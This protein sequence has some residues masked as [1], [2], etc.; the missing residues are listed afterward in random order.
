MLRHLQQPNQTSAMSW[1]L[2]FAR[3]PA[4][5]AA[6]RRLSVVCLAG[7]VVG[8]AQPLLSGPAAAQSTR[9]AKHAEI[10]GTPQLKWQPAN[11]TVAPGGTVTFKIVGA[12]PHPVG[13][14]AAP[15]NDDGKFDTSGCQIDKLS[16]AGASCTVTFAKAGTYP[17]F[18][19]LHFAT[20]MVGTII[21]GG[22]TAGGTAA[23]S[24][25]AAP[26]VTAPGAVKP[27]APGKPALYWAG[28]G[29][30]VLGA[31]IGL[32]TLFAYMRF[33]PGFPR[34]RR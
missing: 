7:A 21:V 16:K 10:D 32:V 34:R 30:L 1:I 22:G 13:S 20:G 12:T 5:R 15:P 6:L 25:G 11:V 14:G 28:Y 26:L 19:K 31:L 24:A 23:P 17:Y 2:R 27:T 18:C 29:L 4:V 3:R 8:A 9:P 33:S